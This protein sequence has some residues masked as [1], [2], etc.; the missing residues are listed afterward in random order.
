MVHK[1]LRLQ[2]TEFP[3]FVTSV[4]NC[5]PSRT[6]LL[7]GR[8]CHNNNLTANDAPHGGYAGFKEK[9]LDD[10]YLPFW[11]KDAGYKTYWVGKALNGF[12]TY[13]ADNGYFDIIQQHRALGRGHHGGGDWAAG[14]DLPRLRTVMVL[15]YGFT[16]PTQCIKYLLGSHDQRLNTTTPP[17]LRRRR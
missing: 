12:S 1:H 11:L 7:T 9:K 16:A 6:V 5:C 13:A 14:W 3:Q 10:S 2:G 4:G 8:H 15:H 17:L